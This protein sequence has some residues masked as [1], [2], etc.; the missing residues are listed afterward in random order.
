MYVENERSEFLK[1]NLT[2]NECTVMSYE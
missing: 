2:E 1:L